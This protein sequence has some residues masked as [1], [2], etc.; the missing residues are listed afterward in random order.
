M[1]VLTG[2]V[3]S[4]VVGV[5]LMAVPVAEVGAAEACPTECRREPNEV[6]CTTIERDD[7][8]FITRYYWSNGAD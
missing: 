5:G 4:I 6:L 1:K 2:A 8:P 7:S 3:A